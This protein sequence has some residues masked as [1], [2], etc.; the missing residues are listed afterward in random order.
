ML[1]FSHIP[2]FVRMI[3]TQCRTPLKE[4]NLFSYGKKKGVKF[5]IW[6][7]ISMQQPFL[8]T[9]ILK[10][11]YVYLLVFT[12]QGDFQLEFCNASIS[13]TMR[14]LMEV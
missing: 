9:L 2:K 3:K 8:H 1:T 12:G 5:Y 10:L 11:L 7:P 14:I 13:K 4:K 6:I